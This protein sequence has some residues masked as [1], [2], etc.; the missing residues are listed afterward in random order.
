MFA[1]FYYNIFMASEQ[2]KIISN[3]DIMRDYGL[4]LDTLSMENFKF[5]IYA[6]SAILY[7]VNV[8]LLA[9]VAGYVGDNVMYKARRKLRTFAT[10]EI[11]TVRK[12][13]LDVIQL[14]D[15]F[16]GEGGML[17]CGTEMSMEKV[18]HTHTH[19]YVYNI[20]RTACSIAILIPAIVPPAEC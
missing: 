20:C 3:Y 14:I 18:I 1:T 19:T 17:F 10:T 12:R 16:S 6:F 11:E 8:L 4:P 9:A 7:V 15:S 2:Y 5:A 13:V